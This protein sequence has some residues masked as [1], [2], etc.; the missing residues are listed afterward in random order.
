[1]RRSA[2][3]TGGTFCV[4]VLQDGAVT[5]VDARSARAFARHSHDEFGIGLVT[6][7]AQRSWSGRGQVEA[8]P[9]N[10]ITVNPAEVHDGMPVDG[11]RA[12]S[13]LYFS[14]A[15]VSSVVSD[16]SEGRVSGGELHAPVVDDARMARRFRTARAAIANG[17]DAEF[18]EALL[19]L[20]GAL[21]SAGETTP[22]GT[23]T[24]LKAVR[25]CIDDDP[26]ARHS[27]AALARVS[28]MS[29]FQTLRGFARLT[30]FTP[31][32]YVIQRRLD[33]ARGLI[34]QGSPLAD[35]A[36]GAGFADQSHMHRAFVARYGFTPGAYAIAHRP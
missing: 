32:A 7:G 34:R 15:L 36:A 33:L 24:G 21:Q 12:W 11:P 4:Q 27:L 25:A 9:G 2:G 13:M 20:F 5:A 8:G 3:M 22:G 16:L 19:L 6:E 18:E 1:M 17:Q 29:R 28:G 23:A 35:A 30:G 26:A 10:L 31:R 14:P